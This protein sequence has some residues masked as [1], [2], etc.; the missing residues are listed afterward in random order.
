MDFLE[1]FWIFI[2]ANC[3]PA[4][5]KFLLKSNQKIMKNQDAATE[6]IFIRDLEILSRKPWLIE[7]PIKPSIRD[8]P[9]RL[10]EI[11]LRKLPRFTDH[12]RHAMIMP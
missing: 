1:R 6:I 8:L 10:S 7:W 9:Y 2:I 12:G 11:L 5:K 4:W 3:Q